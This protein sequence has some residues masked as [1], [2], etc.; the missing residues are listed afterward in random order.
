MK[1]KEKVVNLN[2]FQNA[3][4]EVNKRETMLAW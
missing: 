2:D 3:L 1:T 4:N